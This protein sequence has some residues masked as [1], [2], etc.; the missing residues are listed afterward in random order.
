MR[1]FKAKPYCRMLYYILAS[2]LFLL[3]GITWLMEV[4]YPY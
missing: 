4:G 3:T 2:F 1:P